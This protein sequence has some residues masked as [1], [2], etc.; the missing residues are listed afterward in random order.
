[1]TAST[2]SQA[3]PRTAPGRPF[4]PNHPWDRNFFLLWVGLIW[5]GIYPPPLIHLI[6]SIASFSL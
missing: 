6:Q 2:L 4:P 3:A 5:L 1:M